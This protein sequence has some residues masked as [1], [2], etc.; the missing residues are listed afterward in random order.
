MIHYDCEAVRD[1]IDAW[2][3]G[4]LDAEEARALEAHLA[5]CDECRAL[6]DTAVETAA[7]LGLA[8]PMHAAS[9]T[10]KSRVMASAAI[11]TDI[12][13]PRRSRW[14]W[15]GAVAALVVG[16]A[17]AASWAAVTQSRVN[18]LEGQNATLSA[19]ATAQSRAFEEVS[20][21]EANH[22]QTIAT[23]D[24]MLE[25][26]LQPDAQ[27]TDLVGT[28]MAPEAT[29]RCVWSQARESGA[30]LVDGLPQ[31]R[32]GAVYTMWI[33][34]ER[35]WLE[36]GDFTVDNDGTGRLV[37]D[38]WGGDGDDGDDW[39]AFEGFAVTTEPAS[40]TSGDRGDTIMRS[41]F[42]D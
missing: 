42:S 19:G 27:R 11:L 18:D 31:P 14:L 35:K 9:A 3:L 41:V 16:A 10:L 24:A 30:L 38:A 7:S 12:R 33:V 34:Y 13:R 20:A 37:M 6:A 25:V 2:A 28:A 1:D 21:L 8:V 36:A 39:G 26:V 32:E 17:G 22:S 40:G 15:A 5:S 23:Q 29:G 4:A